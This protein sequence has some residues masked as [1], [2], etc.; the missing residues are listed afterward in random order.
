MTH[1][2]LAF[3]RLYRRRG[4]VQGSPTANSSRACCESRT[5]IG[6]RGQERSVPELQV[7]LVVVADDCAL[8]GKGLAG[9]RGIAGTVFVHKVPSACL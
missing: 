1:A 5:S 9:R 4:F 7:E 8:E 2:L 6:A 3:A